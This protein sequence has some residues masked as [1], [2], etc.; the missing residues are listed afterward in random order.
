MIFPRWQ[1]ISSQARF[2]REA[3]LAARI[4]RGR[5]MDLVGPMRGGTV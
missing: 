5:N 1:T 4:G 3:G 2:A